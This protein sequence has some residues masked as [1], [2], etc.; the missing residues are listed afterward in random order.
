MIHPYRGSARIDE[1]TPEKSR[2]VPDWL[3]VPLILGTIFLCYV[4]FFVA[5]FAFKIR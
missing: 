4:L 2:S 3:D 5:G 1:A